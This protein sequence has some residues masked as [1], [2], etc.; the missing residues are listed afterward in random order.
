MP[1]S[2]RPVARKLCLSDGRNRVG[3]Q[4][5]NK[6][7]DR[8][9]RSP[10]PRQSTRSASCV[11]WILVS[12][13]PAADAQDPAPY[14]PVGLGETVGQFWGFDAESAHGHAFTNAP[15]DPDRDTYPVL[16]F[17]AAG[18]PPL[19]L[20][21][22]LEDVASHGYVIVGV[23]HTYES[24]LT[25]FPDG[26]VAPM[27]TAFMQPVFGAYSGEAQVAI[28][29]R[30][31]I[32]RQKVADMRF[33]AEQ[34][35]LLNEGTGPL[36]GRLDLSRLGAFGH[37]MG[38]DAALE[39]CRASEACRAA[40]NLDGGIW[41]EV[42][43]VGVERPTLLVLADHTDIRTPC[44]E[45]VKIGLYPSVEW[46]EAERA[47]MVNGW[48]TAYERGRP[49]YALMMRGAV[50]A[51]FMDAP[52]LPLQP[53]SMLA[54]GMAAATST[55]NGHG[56]SPAMHCSRSSV[57]TSTASP[58]RSS[59]HRFPPTRPSSARR[60]RCCWASRRLANTLGRRREHLCHIPFR[61]A[62]Q[63]DWATSTSGTL[64]VRPTRRANHP[65]RGAGSVVVSPVSRMSRPCS[66]SAAPS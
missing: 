11:Y 28:D 46:C 6:P 24:I 39:Y 19:S 2:F 15:V 36:A 22:I 25:V 45:H 18:F 13:D 58:P 52:F 21:A 48:Q 27:N 1:E 5:R 50:H 56:E 41:G 33:V 9:A 31:A 10:S 59:A 60:N 49:G 37:S 29:G 4:H 32:V 47:V 62:G 42:G 20:S 63:W 61:V 38:G 16:V 23:N 54:G 35:A 3:R 30:A 7:L 64:P 12:A 57:R 44:E 8:Q 17:S 26:R 14:L 65:A 34:V 53:G 40:A 55:A 51:S 66:S 43:R